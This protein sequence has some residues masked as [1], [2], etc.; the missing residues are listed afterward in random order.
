MTSIRGIHWGMFLSQGQQLMEDILMA[1]KVTRS[2]EGSRYAILVVSQM[3]I[4][5]VILGKSTG[6]STWCGYWAG[7]LVMISCRNFIRCICR[8]G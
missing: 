3:R 1:G 4:F 7:D 5:L 6:R 8:L 2:L